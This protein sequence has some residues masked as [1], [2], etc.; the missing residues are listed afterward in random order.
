MYGK[1]MFTDSDNEIFSDKF[2]DYIIEIETRTAS[3]CIPIAILA[4]LV[5]ISRL[6]RKEKKVLILCLIRDE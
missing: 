5:F 6:F 3:S 1:A 2:V 4:P